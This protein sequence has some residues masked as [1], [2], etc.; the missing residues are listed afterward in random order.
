MDCKTYEL[1]GWHMTALYS[2][3]VQSQGL[4]LFF[5]KWSYDNLQ[6]LKFSQKFLAMHFFRVLN[7]LIIKKNNKQISFR[8]IFILS[9]PS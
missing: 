4:H 7:S 3:G 6:C 1:N 9:I 5:I 2:R 8:L